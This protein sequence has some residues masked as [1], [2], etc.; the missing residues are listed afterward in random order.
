MCCDSWCDDSRPAQAEMGHD[1]P[2]ATTRA[3][4]RSQTW[5][6]RRRGAA[7]P[8]SESRLLVVRRGEEL[9]T[10]RVL[11]VLHPLPRLTSACNRRL[12]CP[13]RRPYEEVRDELRRGCSDCD[14]YRRFDPSYTPERVRQNAP[15]VSISRTSTRRDPRSRGRHA[16]PRAPAPRRRP[17]ARAR[18]CASPASPEQVVQGC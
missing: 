16:N 14:S 10:D 8:R 15:V 2:G 1:L 11:R 13:N 3:C 12:R 5:F 6:C 4:C 9:S 7:Q 17:A 18:P